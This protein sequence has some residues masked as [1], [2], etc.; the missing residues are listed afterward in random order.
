MIYAY[1]AI[2]SSAEKAKASAFYFIFSQLKLVW[3]SQYSSQEEI[4]KYLK[5]LAN[6]HGLYKVAKFRHEVQNLEWLE[7]R[8]KWKANLVELDGNRDYSLHFDFVYDESFT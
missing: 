4:L 1:F 2:R 3:S 5:T 7:D 8:M 6:K